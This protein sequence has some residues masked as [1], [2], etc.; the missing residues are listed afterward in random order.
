MNETH[1][2]C[3]GCEHLEIVSGGGNCKL[4]NVCWKTPQNLP[5]VYVYSLLAD[6]RAVIDNCRINLDLNVRD[7]DNPGYAGYINGYNKALN[8]IKEKLSEHFS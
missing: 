1:K 4:D 3:C 2:E 8:D 7:E 5:R 6:V